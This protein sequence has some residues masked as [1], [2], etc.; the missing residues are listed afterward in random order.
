MLNQILVPFIELFIMIIYRMVK[1]LLCS[2]FPKHKTYIILI[3]DIL[4]YC[5]I[6]LV[7]YYLS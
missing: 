5:T 3:C 7:S 2:R 6:E 4:Q 1:T